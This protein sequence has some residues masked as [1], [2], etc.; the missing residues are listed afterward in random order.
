MMAASGALAQERRLQPGD[1]LIIVVPEAGGLEEYAVTVDETGEVSVG[2]YGRVNLQGVTVDDAR[3]ILRGHLREYIRNTSGVLVSLTQRG[4]L[5]Y[6]TGQ[7]EEPG[8]LAIPE[9]ADLWIAIQR[10]GGVLEGADLSQVA[11]VRGSDEQVIDLRAYL[12]RSMDE[13][14][15]ALRPGDTIFVPAEPGIPLAGSAAGAFL[16]DDALNNKI[17]I[18]G[19]VNEP[20]LFDR[21]PGLNP[22]TALALAEGPTTEADLSSVRFVTAEGSTIIDMVSL[23]TGGDSDPVVFPSRGAAIFFVP[24]RSDEAVNP[25]AQTVSVVGGVNAPGRIE[26]GGPMPL[27]EVLAAAGGPTVDSEFDELR[28]VQQRRHHTMALEYDLELYLEEGGMLGSVMVHPGDVLY[29]PGPVAN[30]W[31]TTIEVIGDLAVIA[32]AVALYVTIQDGI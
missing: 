1:Q 14:L 28:L 13:E 18:L 16:D 31:E 17:F 15:P 6:V 30:V 21:S 10:A 20:G 26:V 8:L 5:V 29:V 2:F 7:V 24:S 27:V 19:A 4:T 32:S 12:T 22:L 11:L 23:M 9:S 3:M 25:F